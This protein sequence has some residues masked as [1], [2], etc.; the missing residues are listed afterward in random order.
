MIISISAENHLKKFSTHLQKGFLANLG[1]ERNFFNLIK[2]IDKNPNANIILNG[3]FIWNCKQLQI[4]KAIKNAY[5]KLKNSH[6]LVLGLNPK[7]LVIKM[8]C[9][10]DK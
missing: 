5:T 9:F 6:Y 1:Q 10:L 3:K 2:G 4:V 8:V 7:A